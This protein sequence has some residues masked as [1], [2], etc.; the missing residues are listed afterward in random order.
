MSQVARELKMLFY[1]DDKL[2][3]NKNWVKISEL[4]DLLEITPRQVRRYRDD[5]E[6]AGFYIEEKRG[7]DGGYKLMEPLNNSLMIPDNIMLALSISVKNNESLIKS[8]KELPIAPTTNYNNIVSDNYITDEQIDKLTVLVDSINRHLSVS[9]DYPTKSGVREIT[10]NPYKLLYTNH[11]YYLKGYNDYEQ[12]LRIYDVDKVSN[13]ELLKVFNIDKSLLEKIE[14]NI[15][16]YGIKDDYEEPMLVRL[17]Y[18]D[19]NDLGMINRLFEYKGTADV[20]DK[21]FTVQV[22]SENEIF[23]PIFSLG[24]KVRILNDNIKSKYI[25]YMKK[26]LSVLE[27]QKN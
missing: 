21:I 1:L 9:F 26:Q 22:I 13:I 11:T 6:Q 27:K 15:N 16:C 25:T 23:Y 14:K 20:N 24:S 5:I 10:V 17:Q 12:N 2:K 8:L 18:F 4:S 19:D 3:H 7:P